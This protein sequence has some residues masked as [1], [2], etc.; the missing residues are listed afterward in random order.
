MISLNVRLQNIK[1]KSSARG[2]LIANCDTPQKKANNSIGRT[3]ITQLFVNNQDCFAIIKT[4]PCPLL[5][6]YDYPTDH[7]LSM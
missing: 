3:V 1:I 6:T 2:L 7:H 4:P 5:S